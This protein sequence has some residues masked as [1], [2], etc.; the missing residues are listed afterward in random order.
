[1]I[2]AATTLNKVDILGAA[3]LSTVT[4]SLSPK[5][6]NTA[7]FHPVVDGPVDDPDTY[8]KNSDSVIVKPLNTLQ[9]L[10]NDHFIV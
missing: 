8:I 7:S 2:D 5:P 6:F 10:N 1:M 9:L 4:T 3:T